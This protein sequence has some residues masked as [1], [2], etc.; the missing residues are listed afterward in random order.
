MFAE[1]A[2]SSR[3]VVTLFYN[4]FS[5]YY[6][7][8]EIALG[9]LLLSLCAFTRF[10]P[11][12]LAQSLQSKNAF[13]LHLIDHMDSFIQKDGTTNFMLAGGTIYAGAKIYASRVDNVG[14]LLNRYVPCL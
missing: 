6:I 10:S 11:L 14:T 2:I 9:S 7:C 8:V 13:Q 12:L 3:A 5:S 1:K 4:I